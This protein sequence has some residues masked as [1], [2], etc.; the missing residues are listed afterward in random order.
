[1]DDGKNFI[2]V[3]LLSGLVLLLW[4][5]FFGLRH[6]EKPPPPPRE[7]QSQAR[8]GRLEHRQ[9]PRAATPSPVAPLAQPE[10]SLSRE[11]ALARSQRIAI[12][13]PQIS[14]SIALTGGRIDDVALK[15]YHETVDKTSPAIELLSPSGSPHPFYAA[16]GWLAAPGTVEKLPTAESEWRQQGSGG[17]GVGHPVTLAWDNGEGLHFR[18][19][20]S[21]D[22]EYLFSIRDEV[23]NTGTTS[24]T[25]SP[26]ALI[27]RHGTPQTLGYYILHEGLIG[28]FGDHGL[29][30]VTY[31]TID[32]KRRVTFNTTDV[33]LG[34]TDKYWAAALL[35]DT[36][37]H[38]EAEFVAG[39][40]GA[41]KTYQTD[42]ELD[43]QTIA[44]GAAG[45]AEARLFA[46]A[47]EV[48]IIDDYQ[49]TL[50]LNRFDLL[51][52]W[53]WFYFIT[54]P[55]FRLIDYF[56]R[57]VG[58]FGVAIMIPY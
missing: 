31:K 34:I 35:P 27:S 45:S 20:I 32:E 40:I 4:Q 54:K 9:E 1:M 38:V 16:F 43:P 47:K 39:L 17:L 2:L 6:I 57:L 51:I 11:Q 21:V 49:N 22:D 3:I 19:T 55:M 25:L 28:V 53:G 30:D 24:V 14:G 12:D 36:S 23:S 44:S 46:G 10:R 42:Y 56:Y 18:R 37:A 5:Y 26:Y 48:S 7:E 41:V 33:W 50:H 8:P 29:Q 52:D 15:N 13:T 58:N